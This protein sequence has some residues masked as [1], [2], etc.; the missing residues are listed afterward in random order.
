MFETIMRRSRHPTPN[1]EAGAVLPP[2]FQ[3]LL[4]A[5]GLYAGATRHAIPSPLAAARLLL[6]SAAS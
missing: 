4:T 1:A 6:D 3:R 5:D 2:S